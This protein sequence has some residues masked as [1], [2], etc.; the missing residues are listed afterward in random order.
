MCGGKGA[1]TCSRCRAV[2][3]LGAICAATSLSSWAQRS[4]PM[5]SS[6]HRSTAPSCITS[7]AC[8]RP[9]C[10]RRWP[11]SGSETCTGWLAISPCSLHASALLATHAWPRPGRTMQLSIAT[12][13]STSAAIFAMGLARSPAAAGRPASA[14]D[15]AGGACHVGPA[16]AAACVADGHRSRCRNGRTRSCNGATGRAAHPRAARRWQA[17]DGVW[18]DATAEPAPRQQQ[19]RAVAQSARARGVSEWPGRR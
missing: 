18:R 15:A 6:S 2:V 12:L 3:A 19:R 16:A 17:G 11:S 14:P 13:H 8:V 4:A 9:F 1:H 7:P 10:C 5:P